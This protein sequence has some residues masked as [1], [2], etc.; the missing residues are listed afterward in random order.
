[1]AKSKDS[2]QIIK[3]NAI[4]SIPSNNFA[5]GYEEIG[6]GLLVLVKNNKVNAS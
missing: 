4:P 1:M 6:E 5:A 2:D 3:I